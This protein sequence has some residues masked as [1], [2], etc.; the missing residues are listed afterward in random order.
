MTHL[1]A[2][3]RGLTES[4][5]L[6]LPHAVWSPLYLALHESLVSR[7]GLLNFFHDFLR[8]A[9]E[10]R[11][12]STTNE[13]IAAHLSIADYFDSREID[14]R[15]ID[16]LPWQLRQ[17]ESWERLKDC[18]T[19]LDIFLKLR[20]DE[21]QYE[22]MGYWLAM[23]DRFDM[24]KEYNASLDLYEKASPSEKDLAYMLN[25]LAIFLNMNVKLEGA[26]PLYRRAL[27]ISEKIL[28]HE[29]PDTALSL[30]SL[31]VLLYNKGD[32]E[33]AKT[34]MR[35]ALIIFEKIQGPEH[36]NT[37]NI[38]NNLKALGG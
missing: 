18:V 8:K 12:L 11:Y 7:S 27:D 1:W 19:D 14:D 3:R 23:G 24:V 10:N 13:K 34:Y 20:T 36:P 21:R 22:L 16:E 17:A 32:Y 4:E 5:L 2:S 31:A 33:G 25:D 37:V 26:E 6:E 35:K 30:N 28:G 15:K 29:H 38:R 9:V